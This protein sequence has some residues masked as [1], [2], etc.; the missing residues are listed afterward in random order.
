[1]EPKTTLDQINDETK[2][3]DIISRDEENAGADVAGMIQLA[4]HLIRQL[5][6]D[7]P[8]RNEWLKRYGTSPGTTDHQRTAGR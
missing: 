2:V 1:M 5:P 8:G 3:N 4:E 6:A 7:H